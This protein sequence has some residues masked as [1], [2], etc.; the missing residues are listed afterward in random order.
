MMNN[1]IEIEN[2]NHKYSN[3]DVLCSINFSV[4]EGNF[5]SIVGPNGGGKTT[6]LKLILGLDTPSEGNLN[7]L[8]YVPHKVPSKWISYV[9]QIKTLERSFPA[10]A[11]E[12]VAN[13]ITGRWIGRTP[14]RIL[15]LAYNILEQIGA[16]HLAFKPLNQLSGGELQRIYLAR[17]FVKMPRLLLLDEPAT[18]IDIAGEKD[19]NKIIDEFRLNNHTTVLMVTHDWEAAYHHSDFVLLLN[20]KQICFDKPDKAFSDDNLRKAFRHTDHAHEMTFG[21]KRND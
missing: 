18:G 13:G 12:L 20:V 11:Y 17:S 15:D 14:K 4:K 19:I 16:S 2:L 8:G 5:I 6:L 1:S 9:P 3:F 10:L 7:V 21:V